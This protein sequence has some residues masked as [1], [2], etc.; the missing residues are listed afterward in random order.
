[1]NK[2]ISIAYF[3]IRLSNGS[4]IKIFGYDEKADYIFRN[5]GIGQFLTI[6]GNIRQRNGLLEIEIERINKMV[7]F[8]K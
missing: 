1:M 3:Y 7:H 4:I 2:K 5:I 6:E 8:M